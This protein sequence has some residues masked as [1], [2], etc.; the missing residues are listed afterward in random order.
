MR[1]WFKKKKPANVSGE[2]VPA[3]ETDAAAVSEVETPEDSGPLEEGIK[4]DRAAVAADEP[5]PELPP[6]VAEF[7]IIPTAVADSEVE[8]GRRSWFR[9]KKVHPVSPEAGPEPE[10]RSEITE[11]TVPEASAQ[12]PAEAISEPAVVSPLEPEPEP[13]ISEAE[14]EAAV[15]TTAP[16]KKGVFRRLRDRLGRTREALAHGLDRLFLGKK[17]IDAEL[18][19]DLEELLITADLGVD[20]T[21]TLIDAVREKVRRKELSDPSRLKSHLKAE[22]VALLQT[23]ASN[24][25]VNGHP[26]VVMVIGVN[27][28]G[29]TTTI[30]KLAHHDRVAG[31]KVLLVAADTFRAAAIE[32]L[33]IWGQRVG[34]EVIK[35]KSGSDPAAVV[36]DGLAAAQSRQVD[37]VYIDTAG[38]LHTKVNLM[39][40]LKK[41]KRTATRQIPSAPHEVYLVL[42]ATTG[43]NAI[44]QARMFHEALGVTG[45]ILT[46]LD[47]TAKGGV[48]LGVVKETGLPL[49]YIGVGESME[50][51]RPFEAEAFIDAI[52]G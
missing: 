32:Q 38:R 1:K 6:P 50:E 34:A 22:M 14:T 17:V 47:G 3:P 7:T 16:D 51:L 21:L 39:E 23:P 28:V 18:L 19:E 36:F 41:I 52:L 29:K 37:M 44:S 43:Q 2:A 8:T 9:R 10:P 27:G 31:R 5:S 20:T 15:E 42:D 30:A 11:P 45:L 12:L 40:E 24:P 25:V 33:E 4:S 13:L 49:R 46:K 26:R 48:A 35:Q